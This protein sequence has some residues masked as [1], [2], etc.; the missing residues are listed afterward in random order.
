MVT[1]NYKIEYNDAHWYIYWNGLELFSFSVCLLTSVSIIQ[2]QTFTFNI[3]ISHTLAIRVVP[4]FYFRY[5]FI[6]IILIA[7]LNFIKV[8]KAWLVCTK[9]LTTN[10]PCH[11]YLNH[12]SITR[13]MFFFIFVIFY[14][15]YHETLPLCGFLELMPK[16]NTPVGFMLLRHITF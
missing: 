9:Y 11:I 15:L 16:Q 8:L 10:Q 6:D 1:Q 13:D 5:N 2:M 7:I 14:N 4:F 3:A 12:Q